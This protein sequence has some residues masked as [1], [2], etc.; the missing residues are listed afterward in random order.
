M[1]GW[2]VQ[3]GGR[4][5]SPPSKLVARGRGLV[6]GWGEREVEVEVGVEGI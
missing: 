6:W 3:G 5:L 2:V 1:G 4:G